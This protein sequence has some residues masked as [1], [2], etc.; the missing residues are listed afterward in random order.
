V[1]SAFPD[2]SIRPFSYA[3]IA[4]L[5]RDLSMIRRPPEGAVQGD[6]DLEIMSRKNRVAGSQKAEL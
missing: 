1:N 3:K 2:E 6:T 4:P 5:N